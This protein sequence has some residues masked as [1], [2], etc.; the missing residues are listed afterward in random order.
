MLRDPRGY[1][2]ILGV[3]EQLQKR[4]R[5]GYNFQFQADTSNL[6]RRKELRMSVTRR[7]TRLTSW[8]YNKHASISYQATDKRCSR[9]K[10]A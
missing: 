9:Y 2:M 8:C 10:N 3:D 5:T 4:K 6:I 1:G 7:V